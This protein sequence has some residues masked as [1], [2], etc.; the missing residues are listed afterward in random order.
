MNLR[1]LSVYSLLSAF[2]TTCCFEIVRADETYRKPPQAILDVLHAP[3]LPIVTFSPNR[4][5]LVTYHSER[6]PAI[7]ELARPMLRLAGL[8][9]DPQNNGLHQTGALLEYKIQRLSTKK[10]V[11][12]ALPTKARVGVPTWSPDSKK[13]AFT[14]TFSDHIELW[15]GDPENGKTHRLRTAPI[16]S[17]IGAAYEW[18]SDSKT[19]LTQ[20]VPSERGKPLIKPAVPTGPDIQESTGKRTTIRTLTDLLT[21]SFDEKQFDY[22]ATAQLALIDANNGRT[23]KVG[24]PA[25]F[26]SVVP[27]PDGSYFITT[28]IKHPYSYQLSVSAFPKLVEVWDRDGNSVYNI[29]KPPAAA[30]EETPAANLGRARNYAWRPTE[31]ASLIWLEPSGSNP[32]VAPTDP[33][34]GGFGQ[35]RNT[36]GD[37]LMS[38]TAPFKG[39]PTELLKWERRIGSLQWG[40]KDGMILIS[41]GGAGRGPGG[42]GAAGP[43]GTGGGGRTSV[44]Y[45]GSTTPAKELW[46]R[47]ASD[48][49]NDP[50]APVS[51]TLP[52]GVRAIAQN[53]DEI[54][55]TG[56][57]ASPDGDHPFL[58]KVNI[59][60]G[61]RTKLF[62]SD[63]KSYETFVALSNDSTHYFTRKETESEPPVYLQRTVVGSDIQTVI[64]LK[65]PTPQ[66]RGIR[67][68]LVTYKRADGVQCS[69]TLYL[70]ADYK[71]GTR[72]PT[73]IW[74]YPREFA[75]ADA[76]GAISGS[77]E[78][79]TTISGMSHLFFLLQGYAVLDN[80]SMPIVG[81]IRTANDN[82]VDQIVMSAK[83]AIDKAV[84]MGVT[85]RDRVGVGGHSYGAF[86]TANLLAHSDLFRAGIAR[87]G[88]YNRTLTPFGFQ[89]ERR[90][91][92]Q[93]PDLYSKMSPFNYA[94]KIKDPILLIHGEAD[95]NPG[96][97]TIQT[98]RM[99]AA[100]SG[101][102]GKV[103]AVLLPE[104]AHGYTAKESLETVL[105]E[106]I[107]W[108][109]K[110]VKTAKPRPVAATPAVAPTG[111]GTPNE[112]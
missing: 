60:T 107:E 45:V 23:R 84:E 102:G 54:F 16:S 68:Q 5:Y 21:N 100:I 110:Y 32:P 24:K 82:F 56:T 76:A 105:A 92:W 22:F 39:T 9:I 46:T 95:N 103:R 49:Y 29:S 104:E 77:T 88:A 109:E 61:Q 41:E 40:G 101:N 25:I 37:R 64:A 27:S 2:A 12:L 99:Y 1:H 26:Q 58:D 51:R 18:L 71:P 53:G 30:E 3:G 89:N 57:G 28:Q 62:K 50:G 83:A 67:K 47:N 70:P 72:L 36:G 73:V 69:F 48:R 7:T 94:E 91:F 106:M 87:S 17:V 38:L 34:S 79:F 111:T 52:N 108:F 66:I 97:F 90:T 98:E 65:D 75:D 4:E 85:D 6:Y 20:L 80:A 35:R 59:R 93:A 96:T 43:G 78:R 10:E 44:A 15:V 13:L 81:P 11:D 74:A 55:L 31:A 86:M 14:A 8:R 63:E 42:P 33:T 112:P 19:L